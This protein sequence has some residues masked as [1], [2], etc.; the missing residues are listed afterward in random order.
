MAKSVVDKYEQILS[1]DP[2]STVFVELA[3]ALLQE[4]EAEQAITAC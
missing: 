3:K 4:G 1:K 2:S